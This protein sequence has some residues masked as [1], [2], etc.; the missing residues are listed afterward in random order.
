LT[1]GAI[2]G[3]VVGAVAGGVAIASLAFWF[4]QRR[5]KK[6][7]SQAPMQLTSYKYHAQN[8]KQQESN[9][10]QEMDAQGGQG[11][12]PQKPPAELES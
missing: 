11:L 3:V 10:P 2:A 1:K 8:T 6:T 7:D 12:M 9:S 4:L 5:K